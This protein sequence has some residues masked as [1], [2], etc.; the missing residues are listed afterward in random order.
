[1]RGHGFQRISVKL[2][3]SMPSFAR[4]SAFASFARHCRRFAVRAS[5]RSCAASALA[6]AAARTFPHSLDSPDETRCGLCLL[7]RKKRA[8]SSQKHQD[9]QRSTRGPYAQ[10][11][12]KRGSRTALKNVR[13]ASLSAFSM[14]F[15]DSVSRCNYKLCAELLSLA[16]DFNCVWLWPLEVS[17]RPRSRLE[18]FGRN[19]A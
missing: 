16:L 1:M 11:C 3:K 6:F 13:Q 10:E 4:R 12:T 5:A 15:E 2:P 17:G 19:V 9:V 14:I 18:R 7:C 8:Q